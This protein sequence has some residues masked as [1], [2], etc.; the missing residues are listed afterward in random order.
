M[1]DVDCAIMHDEIIQQIMA[2]VIEIAVKEATGQK[3]VSRKRKREAQDFLLSDWAEAWASR[4]GQVHKLEQV[5]RD[6]L[7]GAYDDTKGETRC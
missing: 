3:A 1:R 7:S 2:K 4:L 5:C 6:I